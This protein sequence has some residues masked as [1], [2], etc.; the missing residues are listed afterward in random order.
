VFRGVA[1]GARIAWTWMSERTGM[2]QIIVADC[3]WRYR[4]FSDKAHGAARAHYAGM[5]L[6]EL[7]RLRVWKWAAPDAVLFQWGTW[8]KLWQAMQLIESWGFEYVT[9]I[10]WIKTSPSSGQIRRGVGFW[11]MGA[12][13]FVLIGRRGKPKMDRDEKDTPI[14][15]LIG[16]GDGLDRIFY[17]PISKHSKKPEDLQSYIEARFDGPYLELFATREREGWDCLGHDTGWHLHPDEDPMLLSVAQERGL[18]AWEEPP[19][20]RRKEEGGH[21]AAQDPLHDAMVDF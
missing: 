8:P 20:Q 5:T 12:S 7:S 9:G 17:G 10:P 6:T 14:G 21:M 16:E 19:L 4:N 15:L 3:P 13:E 2:Y 11:T 1:V 18:V